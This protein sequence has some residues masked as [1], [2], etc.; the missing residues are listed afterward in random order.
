MASIELA[1]AV[2]TAL[3]AA[4][5]DAIAVH[6]GQPGWVPP[7]GKSVDADGQL[8]AGDGAAAPIWDATLVDALAG[9]AS[10]PDRGAVVVIADD[11]RGDQRW[12]DAL[13]VVANAVVA[14][15]RGGP[16]R[17]K[18]IGIRGVPAAPVAATRSD[19]T[20]PADVAPGP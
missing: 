19:Q 1:R 3:R 12:S 14:D 16:V 11:S 7:R 9:L 8:P 5:F 15:P 10:P 4:G 6:S 2:T 18:V 17:V 13:G 20:S